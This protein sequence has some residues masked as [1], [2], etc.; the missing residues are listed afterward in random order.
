VW[1]GLHFKRAS[2]GWIFRSPISWTLGL[3]SRRHYL[4]NETQ[5]AEIERVL[6]PGK[7]M[8]LMVVSAVPL[9][10]FFILLQTHYL[11]TPWDD[12]QSTIYA[13]II[14]TAVCASAL[15]N[16][17]YWLALRST[18]AGMPRTTERI[19]LMEQI[20]IVAASAPQGKWAAGILLVMSVTLLLGVAS[21]LYDLLQL[22]NLISSLISIVVGSLGTCLFLA[23]FT[24][25]LKGSR[26]VG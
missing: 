21:S 16:A 25:K 14:L 12:F 20:G 6:P 11:P 22:K 17:G 13:G 8:T 23:L 18:L 19:T 3:T 24:L 9:L 5:K 4:V 15:Q 7:Q 10:I 2:E 1:E 26:R